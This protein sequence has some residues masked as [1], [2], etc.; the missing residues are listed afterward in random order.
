MKTVYNI[1]QSFGLSPSTNIQLNIGFKKFN[2][3]KSIK[4]EENCRCL[5]VIEESWKATIIE[6]DSMQNNTTENVA[7]IALLHSLL[8]KYPREKYEPPYPLPSYGLNSTT[9]VL[10]EG[11]LWH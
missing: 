8:D 11:W 9:S 1:N 4:D 5:S 6:A 2:R 10:L 3:N 7:P